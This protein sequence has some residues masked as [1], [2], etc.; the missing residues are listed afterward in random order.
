MS[1]GK[2]IRLNTIFRRETGN[3]VI[4]AA[5]H[6]GIA[7]PLPG[8][9]DPHKLVTACVAG[10]ADGVLTTRGFAKA[11]GEAWDR[12]TALILRLTGGFTTL[13]GKFEEQ[14]IS[15][16]E[17]A[18]L[19]GASA[20]AAT[21]KFGHEREGEFI[22]QASLLADECERWGMPLL[23][24]AMTTGTKTAA[25][26]GEKM[27]ALTLA[28]RAAAEIGADI[29]KIRFNGDT[30]SFCRLVE[31]C[32]VP[33]VIAGGEYTADVEV[34]FSEVFNAMAGGAKGIALGRNVWQDRNAKAMV[35]AMTGL[36]HEKWS[37]E[38]ACSYM[39]QQS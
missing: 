23:L 27:A 36:V 11:A 17:S 38:R 6:A 16:V 18:L 35:E 32:T 13:G 37:V 24:E 4:V 3:T 33:V 7:G 14:V 39:Q 34:V 15:T 8:I 9:E 1:T 2:R 29:V 25:S 31:G 12:G 20:V 28:A 21:V 5:D 26:I 19:Y 10:G 30:E 22:R